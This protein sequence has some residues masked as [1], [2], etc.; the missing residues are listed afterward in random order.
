MVVFLICVRGKKNRGI[1]VFFFLYFITLSHIAYRKLKVTQSLG[2]SWNNS[3]FFCDFGMYSEGQSTLFWIA[4]HA[5]DSE[6]AMHVCFFNWCVWEVL[7][8][9]K[10][11]SA[12]K[13]HHS[14]RINDNKAHTTNFNMTQH[15]SITSISLILFCVSQCHSI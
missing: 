10:F 2:M 12:T 13:I 7:D 11:I 1:F 15:F 4:R 9:E 6:F 8:W 14:K 5:N 3:M